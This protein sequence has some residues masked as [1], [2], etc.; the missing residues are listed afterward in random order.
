MKS[1]V[2]DSYDGNSLDRGNETE[3][4]DVGHISAREN[5]KNNTISARLSKEISYISEMTFK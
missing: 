2:M 3:V 5:D 4:S 1:K